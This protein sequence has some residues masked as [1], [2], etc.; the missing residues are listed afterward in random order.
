MTD[1]QQVIIGRLTGVYGIKGWLKVHSFTEP[2]ENILS[3]KACEISRDGQWLPLAIAEGRIHGKGLVVRLQGVDDRDVAA[4]YVGAEIRVS[5]SAMPTLPKGEYYWH[6]LEG[7]KV[8]TNFGGKQL[9]GQVDHL[10]ETGANDVLVVH[11]CEGSIDK[12]ERLLPYVKQFVLEI[13]LAAGEM[14]VDWD[15]A[16]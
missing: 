7:L 5:I 9:L 14:L 11:A 6:Q 13:D 3:Y 10:L 12:Q 1:S 4:S 2:R 15:P 16:F 8:F